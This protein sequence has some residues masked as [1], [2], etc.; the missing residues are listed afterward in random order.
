M[1]AVVALINRTTGGLCTGTLVSP[2]VVLTAKHCVQGPDTEELYPASDFIVGF[3]PAID[4]FHELVEVLSTATTPGAWT[5]TDVGGVAGALLNVDVGVVTLVRPVNVE[6]IPMHRETITGIPG[7]ELTVVGYGGRPGGGIGEK[8]RTTTTAMAQSGFVIVGTP[9]V[10]GGDSG[11]PVL[12][13]VG[14]IIAVSSLGPS[15]CGAGQSAYNVFQ[16]FLE[17]IDAAID[18]G[19]PCD[20]F[21]MEAPPEGWYCAREGCGGGFARGEAGELGWAEPC[22]ADT[23]CVTLHCVDPGDGARRCLGS[24]R[25]GQGEC[26]DGEACAAPEGACGAC[27]GAFQ[28]S[29]RSLGETCDSDADCVSGECHREPLGV[30]YCVRACGDGC[31]AGYA[32]DADRCVRDRD[33][34][35]LVCARAADGG[36]VCER[37]VLLA[38]GGGGC[39]ASGRPGRES[40]LILAILAL[41]HR[42]RR[43]RVP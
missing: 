8:W 10:C 20:P 34:A 36:S 31:P 33:R 28:I 15:D 16:P 24:C 23:D 30:R 11:G 18:A 26:L 7:A 27:V 19:L 29:A 21:A 38:S 40:W 25:A 13:D 32:C 6:P 35:D 22:G 2:W 12:N 42:R 3:G 39:A 43:R 1:P 14:E 37:P 41:L 5:I 4:A 17:M 9:A